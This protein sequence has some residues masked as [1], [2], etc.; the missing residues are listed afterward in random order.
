[1]L[2]AMASTLAAVQRDDGLWNVSLGDPDY[3]PGPEA[4]GTS[5]FVYAIAWGI[6]HGL[7]DR[8][9]YAPV[10][11]R[12]W[13]GLVS[14]AVRADGELG[15]VQGV[16]NQPASSQPVTLRSTRDFGV[17]AFLLA[18]SEVMRLGLDFECP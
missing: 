10:V 4:S 6:N 14:V 3:F 7:L 15:Y 12:G 13:R 5:F 2:R 16:A 8:A 17:G 11:E 1:M 18:G 9:V